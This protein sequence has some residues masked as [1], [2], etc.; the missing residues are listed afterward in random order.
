MLCC[1]CGDT[2]RRPLSIL[3]RAHAAAS[4]TAYD[5]SVDLQRHAAF[6]RNHAGQGE[7]DQPPAQYGIFGSLGRALKR[8]SGMGF[9]Y[10]GFDAT[11]LG[12]VAA[13]DR[14]STR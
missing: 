6:G 8:D 9:L 4:Q 3:P 5:K 14:K 13:L 7:M 11:E 12:V 2:R 1:Q 10:C